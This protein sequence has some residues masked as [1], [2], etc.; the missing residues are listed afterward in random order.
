MAGWSCCCCWLEVDWL[1]DEDAVEEFIDDETD[2]A[3]KDDEDVDEDIEENRIQ[4]D[5][6]FSRIF[7]YLFLLSKIF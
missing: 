6:F 2:E 5:L 7:C 1:T 3:S 4:I